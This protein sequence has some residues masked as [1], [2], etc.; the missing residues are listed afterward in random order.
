M[1]AIVLIQ[2]SV[3]LGIF[4]NRHTIKS[5]QL[6]GA[7][8]AFIIRPFVL[9]FIGHALIAAPISFVLLGLIF[10]GIPYYTDL[11]PLLKTL[12]AH[13]DLFQLGIFSIGITIFG[14]LLASISSW[15]S[16]KKFLKMKIE[17]LY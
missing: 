6:V 13:I 11:F 5:M 16:T 15:L 9:K 14:V 4:A 17:N 12:T 3:R 2:S 7:T 8:H 1:V 10:W